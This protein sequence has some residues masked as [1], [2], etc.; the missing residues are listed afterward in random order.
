VY[1]QIYFIHKIVEAGDGDTG[2]LNF[3]KECLENQKPL[4]KSDRKYLESKLTT[5]T[6]LQTS[7]PIPEDLL[8]SIRELIELG[9]GDHGRLEHIYATIEKG[10]KLFKSDQLYL[11]EELK[12]KEE[13]TQPSVESETAKITKTST[14]ETNVLTQETAEISKLKTKL[15]KSGE[16]IL[17]LEITRTEHQKT[18]QKVQKRKE[19]IE[20]DIKKERQSVAKQIKKAKAE[21]VKIKRQ[22]KKLKTK[23]KPQAKAKKKK[24]PK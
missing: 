13:S 1:E 24:Q 22:A 17:N 7:D 3:I 12:S 6:P 5:M 2:R 14:T 15:A 9:K 20:Q 23:S 10:K 18:A 11:D 16:K 8:M 21:L 4:F 19:K